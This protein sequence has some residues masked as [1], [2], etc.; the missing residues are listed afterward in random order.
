[1]NITSGI[2]FQEI[3]RKCFCTNI[4]RSLRYKAL[5]LVSNYSS[6]AVSYT[7]TVDSPKKYLNS[8]AF[9]IF[10]SRLQERI[11]QQALV[12]IY[13]KLLKPHLDTNFISML[14][15]R[16]ISCQ[17]SVRFGPDLDLFSPFS[18]NGL[19]WPR[20]GAGQPSMKKKDSKCH[21]DAL[22]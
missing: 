21:L 4:K 22:V 11:S 2:S 8:K 15:S 9:R 19:V 5:M 10:I 20:S 13:N 17:S 6:Y 7:R 12:R 3:F 18:L 14:K 16:N 1:M